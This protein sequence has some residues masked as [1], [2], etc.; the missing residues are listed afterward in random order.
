[1]NGW[2]VLLWAVVAAAILI[3][4]GTFA[5]LVF[6][7]RIALFPD[8][9]PALTPAPEETGVVDTSY[10]ILIL[11][12]T[13]ATGLDAQVR[14]AVIN[15]GWDGNDVI[16]GSSATTDFSA[17]TVYYQSDADRPAAIGLADVIGGAELIESDHYADPNDPDARQLTIVI[18]LDSASAAPAPAQTESDGDAE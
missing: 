12:G 7:G 18:G 5:S 6:T 15:A 2:V 3:V 17:T 10:G 9:A 14:D 4:A 16:A 8:A 13:A 1:M 11:N